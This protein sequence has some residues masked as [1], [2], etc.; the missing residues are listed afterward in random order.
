M[1]YLRNHDFAAKKL[2]AVN[3]TTPVAASIDPFFFSQSDF[4][5]ITKFTPFTKLLT[6]LTK[7]TPL[8]KFMT[9][10]GTPPGP[11]PIPDPGPLVPVGAKTTEVQ[12]FVRF[13]NTVFAPEEL[14]LGRFEPLRGIDAELRMLGITKLHQLAASDPYTLASQLNRPREDALRLVDL[15]QHL[16]RGLV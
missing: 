13:G 11:G 16:L 3:G 15:A 5:S 9:T 14:E 12:P 10:F 4:V 1:T 8:T 2:F 7:L 6:T